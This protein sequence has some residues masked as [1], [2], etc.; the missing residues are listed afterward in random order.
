MFGKCSESLL[1]KATLS[2]AQLFLRLKVGLRTLEK[3]Q[4][5]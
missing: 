1:E 4:K 3:H 2:E 5:I